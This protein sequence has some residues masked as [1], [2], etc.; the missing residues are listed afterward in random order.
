MDVDSAMN[1]LLQHVHWRQRIA[2][3]D[4]ELLIWGESGALRTIQD[5]KAEATEKRVSEGFLSVMQNYETRFLKG[6][7][8]LGR[9]I[10]FVKVKNHKM[11]VYPTES[12]ER[13][14]PWHVETARMMMP[15]TRGDGV[16]TMELDGAEIG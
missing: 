10:T 11:G 14:I 12:Y 9:I 5:P 6:Q 1:D 15:E 8:C 4:S 13:F 3:V 7:D 16:R 2:K